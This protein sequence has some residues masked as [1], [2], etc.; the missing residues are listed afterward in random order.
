LCRPVMPRVAVRLAPS[1]EPAMP[2]RPSDL[3][4]L[5]NASEAA[6][7]LG[8][9]VRTLRRLVDAGHGPAPVRVGRCL[10]WR[11]DEV[12]DWIRAGCPR[13]EA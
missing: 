13:R 11:L 2:D 8:V 5:I 4:R 12:S 3:A 6:E 10:R 1:K 7:R 9:S